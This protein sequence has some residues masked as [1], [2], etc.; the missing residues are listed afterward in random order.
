MPHGLA[1]A[2][3]AKQVFACFLRLW[4]AERRESTISAKPC[5]PS[6]GNQ[7]APQPKQRWP[8]RDRIL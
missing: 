4:E 8:A 6:R 1:R 7:T 2:W 5:R 3:L